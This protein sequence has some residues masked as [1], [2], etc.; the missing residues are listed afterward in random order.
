[1][2]VRAVFEILAKNLKKRPFLT[3]FGQY[4]RNGVRNQKSGSASQIVLFFREFVLSFK[5]IHNVEHTELA[6]D[7]LT[8]THTHTLFRIIAQIKF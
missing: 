5:K 3:L 8:H 7:T 2:I 6:D 1:M 4:V